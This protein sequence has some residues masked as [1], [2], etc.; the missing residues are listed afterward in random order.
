M[1][2]GKEEVSCSNLRIYE[3]SFSLDALSGF[4]AC[5]DVP[6]RHAGRLCIQ[7]LLLAPSHPPR[8]L[9]SG[10]LCWAGLGGPECGAT[11]THLRDTR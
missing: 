3:G 5:G 4:L 11:C 8:G 6:P 9:T 10:D 2:G 7:D 1:R